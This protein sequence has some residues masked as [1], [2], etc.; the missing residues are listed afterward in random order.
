MGET[1]LNIQKCHLFTRSC[2]VPVHCVV[3]CPPLK[4]LRRN[5]VWADT[6]SKT[7]K[8]IE[9]KN[10]QYEGKTQIYYYWGYYSGSKRWLVNIGMMRL[11]E[12]IK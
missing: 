4:P 8:N 10:K 11:H 6:E 1:M 12:M 9:E 5:H 7:N 2:W 3:H